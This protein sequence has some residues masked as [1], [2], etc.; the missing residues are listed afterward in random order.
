M[1]RS[2]AAR[3]PTAQDLARN[4]REISVAEFFAKNRHLLGYDNPAKAL[5]TVVREAVDNAL[6]ACEEAGLLPDIRVE[7]ACTRQGTR[8]AEDADEEAT[9]RKP[10]AKRAGPQGTS[11]RHRVVVEDNGPGIVKAQIG[12][13]FGKLLYGSKFHR[14]RMSRGQQGIGISAAALYGQLTTGQPIRITSRIGR[15]KPAHVFEL[16]IDTRT[17]EPKV[18]KVYDDP[19]FASPHGTLIEL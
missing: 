8:A 5:L 3:K 14:L 13:I 10:A 7:I 1:S 9:A 2:A 17:N 18:L 15:T 11:D 6:D 4:Q 12:K 19:P 16:Q